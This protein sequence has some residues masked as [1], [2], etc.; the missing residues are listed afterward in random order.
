[1]EHEREFEAMEELDDETL[2]LVV[3]GDPIGQLLKQLPGG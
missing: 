2:D 1:M 3:G